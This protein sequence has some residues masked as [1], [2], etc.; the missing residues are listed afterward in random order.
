MLDLWG[1]PMMEGYAGFGCSAVTNSFEPFTC[2]LA[3]SKMP[4]HHTAAAIK[5]EYD[6]CVQKWGLDKKVI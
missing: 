5:A 4:L 1:S 6:H 2:F 3:M